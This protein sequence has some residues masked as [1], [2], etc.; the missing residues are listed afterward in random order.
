L[1]DGD[2]SRQLLNEQPLVSVI[3]PAFN[4]G[5]FI[6]ETLNS[7]IAQAYVNLEI[8]VV[9]DG[10]TDDTAAI[11]NSFV[12]KDSRISMLRQNNSG[13]AAA[14]NAGIHRCSGHFIA[15]LDADDICFPNR[16]AEQ[17]L[18]MQAA[19]TE[20][21][22]IYS[23]SVSIDGDSNLTGQV[24]ACRYECD[25]AAEML[26]SNIVG[27]ASASLIRKECIDRVGEYDT[28]FYERDAQ[29][30][31]DR[32]LYLRVAEQ[33]QFSVVRQIH[34]GYRTSAQAMSCDHERMSRSHDVMIEKFRTR[35]PGMAVDGS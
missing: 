23:W 2:K 21:G 33:Y 31:E 5:E 16:I 18:A 32:D 3:I 22:V 6:S 27:N 13:V 1:N 30:C 12:L 15:P 10:S 20:T 29:G 24:N 4:A 35:H 17:V 9:D 34:V 11:V 25:V 26:F 19:G 8:I 14:R 7:V 28:L